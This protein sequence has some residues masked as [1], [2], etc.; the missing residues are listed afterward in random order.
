VFETRVADLEASAIALLR[1]D[2]YEPMHWA[3]GMARLLHDPIP[4]LGL[5]DQI[6]V[7]PTR[8]EDAMPVLRARNEAMA[9]EWHWVEQTE[10]QMGAQIDDPIEAQLD[11]WQVAWD[12]DEVVAGVLGFIDAAENSELG[13][14]RG[15]TE[16]I[17]TRRPWRG[18]GIASSLIARNLRLLEERGMTEAALIVDATSPTGA[19]E[20]YERMGFRRERTEITFERDVE[21]PQHG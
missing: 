20:L 7:R 13:R 11:L 1:A 4:E 2:G 8:R 14:R 16:S 18:R 9:D 17:F 3:H 10:E 6:E 21:G 12:G 15:Y 5:P 19:V